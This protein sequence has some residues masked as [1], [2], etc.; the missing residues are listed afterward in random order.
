MVKVLFVNTPVK[1]K[2]SPEKLP[3]EEVPNEKVH[4]INLFDVPTI[5]EIRA[6]KRV[7][8]TKEENK[9]SVHK[10]KDAST[11]LNSSNVK[12]RNSPNK[13][14]DM[15]PNTANRG[16]SIAEIKEE[17][18]NE[19][20]FIALANHELRFWKAKLASQHASPKKSPK[21]PRAL[22]PKRLK[23]T[24][25]KEQ[26]NMIGVRSHE[27]SW[28]RE[29][30]TTKG[31]FSRPI[32]RM[33]QVKYTPLT[34]DIS[35]NQLDEVSPKRE[36]MSSD[37]HNSFRK[38]RQKMGTLQR[39]SSS[40]INYNMSTTI[41]RVSAR[42]IESSGIRYGSAHSPNKLSAK[43]LFKIGDWNNDQDGNVVK[44]SVSARGDKPGKNVRRRSEK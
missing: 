5:E 41:K 37:L 11:S 10:D 1:R 30:P 38:I 2:P 22:V 33:P 14:E 17:R 3:S 32:V 43:M 42:K 4:I 7:E 8:E 21:D 36:Y 16:Q 27:V 39:V 13:T 24:K 9:Q 6:S 31:K 12:L 23:A 25:V 26:D 35:K 40:G 20:D 34:V 15:S 19:D 44:S 18:K 29:E 28:L